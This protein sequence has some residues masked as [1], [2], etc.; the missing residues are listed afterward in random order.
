MKSNK[1]PQGLGFAR[2]VLATAL[3]VGGALACRKEAGPPPSL[4][5]VTVEDM[6]YEDTA[7]ILA[8]P[9]GT[10]MSRLSRAR[11]RLAA[12]MDHVPAHRPDAHSAPP[13]LRRLK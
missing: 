2:A 13:S 11:S 6:S 4:L 10:V 3:A 8:I 1:L 12:L 9:V 7:R 5:L